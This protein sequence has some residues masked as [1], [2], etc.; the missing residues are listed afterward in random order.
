VENP[1][2]NE[3]QA[4]HIEFPDWHVLL[5]KSA[6]H[7]AL[8]GGRS[9]AKSRTV[10]AKLVLKLVQAPKPG[11]RWL[12]CRETRES[13]EASCKQEIED[14]ID[15]LGLRACFES[16]KDEIL[17]TT[18]GSLF[19]FTGLQDAERRKS[20]AR[21]AGAWIEEAQSVSRRSMELLIPTIREPGSELWWTWNPRYPTDP[22]DEFF[23]GGE[24]P[25]GSVVHRVD[26]RDNPFFPDVLTADMER[27]RRRDPE[28]FRNVWLGDYETKSEASVFR[29]VKVEAFDT[30]PDAR[31][32]F[33]A[34]W[35]ARDPTTLVRA[36][37]GR[38]EDGKA[39]ADGEKGDTIFIDYEAYRR[40]EKIEQLPELFDTVPDSRGW[41]IIADSARPDLIELMQ[42]NRF[43]IRAAKK[44]PGSIEGG[45]AFLQNFD[46]VIHPR[47]TNAAAEFAL[48]SWQVDRH[49]GD[50]LP[51]LRAG[52][53]HTIDAVR[54]AFEG[55][56]PVKQEL[57]FI[58]D[59]RRTTYNMWNDG[60]VTAGR[61]SLLWR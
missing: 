28:K 46:I 22:V 53:D 31:L 33:G 42:R 45:V 59:G 50:V 47:C 40:E 49:T 14:A 41:P 1:I 26:Y 6:R 25:E 27:D 48:Y 61:Q 56:R 44:G 13:I 54:Y 20:T 3:A 34:D 55:A 5:D 23:R 29:N 18:N 2:P 16:T 10:A 43:Q 15:M 30:P 19:M 24:P 58:A 51:K 8:Y 11:L 37:I 57:H 32:R 9:S 36:F 12:C 35:G 39:V 7:K 52:N 38:W 4:L 17:C 21:V 60:I